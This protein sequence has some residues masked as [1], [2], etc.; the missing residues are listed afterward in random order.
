MINNYIIKLQLH[1]FQIKDSIYHWNFSLLDMAWYQYEGVYKRLRYLFLYIIYKVRVIYKT[2]HL[3][4]IQSVTI[5]IFFIIP[6][7]SAQQCIIPEHRENM[8][9]THRKVPSGPGVKPWTFLLWGNTAN[10]S[11]PCRNLNTKSNKKL[12]KYE[13][14]TSLSFK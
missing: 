7:L 9:T 4:F 3:Q 1:Y 2:L 8:Q 13:L 11:P 10:C 12:P 6:L 14:L 5:F